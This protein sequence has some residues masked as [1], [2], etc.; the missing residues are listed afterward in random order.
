MTSSSVEYQIPK[1]LRDS[2]IERL[3]ITFA[4][5]LLFSYAVILFVHRAPAKMKD[6]GDWTYEGVMLHDTLIGHPPPNVVLKHYPVPNSL[7]TVGIALLCFVFPAELAAKVWILIY[8]VLVTLVSFYMYRSWKHCSPLVWLVIPG[9][10]LGVGF[11]WGFVNFLTG[12]LWT[13]V[14]AGMLL[15][16]STSRWKYGAVLV[17]AF[18]THMVPFA[19]ALLLLVCF[20]LDKRR[21]TL[22][23]QSLPAVGL[24]VY[25]AIGRYFFAGNVDGHGGMVSSVRYLSG[26]FWAFKV[27]TYLKSFD[28]VNPVVKSTGL[29]PLELGSGIFLL[30]FS[31]NLVIA[32]I[33]FYLIVFA[34]KREVRTAS[35]TRFFWIAFLL[36]IPLVLLL[37]GEALGVSDP[38]ARVLQCLLWPALW[39]CSGNIRALRIAAVLA[40]LLSCLN[41]W[42]WANLA[43]APP[44]QKILSSGSRSNLPAALSTFGQAQYFG[45]E[46][47]HEALQQGDMSLPVWP[48]GMFRPTVRSNQ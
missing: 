3:C 9:I 8:F 17:L 28:F 32:S 16:G 21:Y 31:L 30:L 11:W 23:W 4:V 42:Q 10:F 19:A 13:T 46:P 15:R 26:P 35:E 1:A 37:P 22:L 2:R 38:G 14:M 25:Y 24:T 5:L 33:F 47:F 48:T 45:G 36:M 7:E 34:I 29:L 43:F 27:N 12:V 39:L 41:I 40:A 18:F 20:S 6:Y 44:P